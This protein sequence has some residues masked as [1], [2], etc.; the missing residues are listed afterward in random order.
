MLL[1][2]TIKMF[3][4]Y[5]S[6]FQKKKTILKSFLLNNKLDTKFFLLSITCNTLLWVRSFLEV[7]FITTFP[8]PSTLEVDKFLIYNFFSIC[9]FIS[10]KHYL[11]SACISYSTSVNSSLLKIDNKV[12]FKN[13]TRQVYFWNFV[14]EAINLG[15]ISLN[16]FFS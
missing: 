4:I 9:F 5:H 6:R 12:N 7:I 15:D 14:N 10:E 13:N 1:T 8:K 2:C 11:L 3:A 16:N